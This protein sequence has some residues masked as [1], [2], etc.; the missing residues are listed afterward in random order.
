M[1]KAGLHLLM[2]DGPVRI[3]FLPDLSPEHRDEFVTLVQSRSFGAT[4]DQF[5]KLLEV[6]A[7]RWGVKVAVTRTKF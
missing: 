4:S 1:V 3:E 7:E 2:R 5:R 6:E